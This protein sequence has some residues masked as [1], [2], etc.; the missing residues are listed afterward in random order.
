MKRFSLLFVLTLIVNFS[1]ANLLYDILDGKYKSKTLE[2]PL[3]MHDGE[4]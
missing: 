4:H 1:F 3:S 2:M